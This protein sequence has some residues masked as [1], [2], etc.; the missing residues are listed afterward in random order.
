MPCCHQSPTGASQVPA[1]FG[2]FTGR[3]EL[4]HV[5]LRT[6]VEWLRDSGTAR[7][8]LNGL[9]VLCHCNLP[10]LLRKCLI[11]HEHQPSVSDSIVVMVMQLFFDE[12]CECPLQVLIRQWEHKMWSCLV[13]KPPVL[14]LTSEMW[15]TNQCLSPLIL[16]LLH[17]ESLT[18]FVVSTEAIERNKSGCK[19]SHRPELSFLRHSHIGLLSLN[20]ATVMI[21]HRL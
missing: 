6:T 2:R 13:S 16:S 4:V 1:V 9:A 15:S 12:S 3:R 11:S 14:M 21:G 5:I 7:S 18:D 20:L 10:A 8:Y 19:Q 17:W